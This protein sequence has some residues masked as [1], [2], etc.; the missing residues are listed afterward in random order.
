MCSS[1]LLVD[2]EDASGLLLADRRPAAVGSV[3]FPMVDG[4][5]PLL[6]ELQSLVVTGPGATAGRRSAEGIDGGRLG[7]LLAVLGRVFEVPVLAAEV[8]CLAVGGVD[9]GDPGA[10]LALACAIVSSLSGRPVPADVVI[11]GEIGLGGEVRTVRH[12][13]R[14]LAEAVRAG[15]RRAIVPATS[16]EVAGLGLIRVRSVGE[17]LLAIGL[18]GPRPVRRTT[19]VEDDRARRPAVG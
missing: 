6:V 10:D 3:V 15:F 7:L 17:A 19:P 1:D 2:V 13:E 12:A 16:P 11:C 14:R 18:G 9:V 4:Q 5:R 8:Y